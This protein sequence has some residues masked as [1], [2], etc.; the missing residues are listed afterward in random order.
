MSLTV[1]RPLAIIDLETTGVNVATDKII[2]IAIVKLLPNGTTVNKRKL[3]N[4]QVAIPQS[5]SDVHGI[6]N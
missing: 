4:Q 5:S 6:T 3:I 1:S 2:E